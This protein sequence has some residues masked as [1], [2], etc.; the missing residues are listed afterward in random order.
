MELN[1]ELRSVVGS[2][3]EVTEGMIETCRTSDQFGALIYELYKE[4]GGLICVTSAAYFGDKGEPIKFDRNQ[5]ICAGLLVRISKLMA[6]VVKLSADIEH[7]EAVQAMNRCIIESAV[8]LRYL[9]HVDDDEVYDRFVKTSLSA[10]RRLYDII[11]SNIENR[12]GGQFVIEEVMLN[13]IMEVCEQS[14]VKIGEVDSRNRSWGD[15][16]YEKLKSLGIE[17][18]YVALYMIPSHAVHGT[19]VD[20][21]KN[22]LLPECDGFEP[23]YDRLNTDG[24]LLSPVGIFVVEAS[25]NYLDKYFDLHDAEPLHQRLDSVQE[26]LMRV[27]SA[28]HDWQ[29]VD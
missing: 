19:W 11:E 4:A 9:L 3:V 28:R 16:F 21:V 23:N 26:R 5:A 2:P 22:H 12:R 6:S 25:R 27:E 13:S 8:N 15:N 7:G 1:D 10:E 17:H 24:E 18:G 20:L 29:I 14:G